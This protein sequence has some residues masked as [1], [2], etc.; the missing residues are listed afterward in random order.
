M[1]PLEDV[2]YVKVGWGGWLSYLKREGGGVYFELLT[3]TK[4]DYV[5]LVQQQKQPAV[6]RNIKW[7]II[8]FY[9][10]HVRGC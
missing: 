10:V 6:V 8:F 9:G 2:F 4:R 3:T 7:Y 5:V 1:F